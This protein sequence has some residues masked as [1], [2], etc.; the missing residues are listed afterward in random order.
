MSDDDLPIRGSLCIPAHELVWRFS[1]SSGPGGQS[2]NTSDS[3]ASLSFNV[4]QS[5]SLSSLQRSRAQQRLEGRLVDGVIT[6]TASDERSQYLNRQSARR[7]L[8]TLLAEAVAPPPR[9]RRKTKPSRAS[10]ERRL[11]GKRRR[12]DIKRNRRNL[13]D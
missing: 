3:R 6:V 9:K 2:V 1:R 4:D 8:A 7:R 11:S 5:S 12:S 13:E 10:I